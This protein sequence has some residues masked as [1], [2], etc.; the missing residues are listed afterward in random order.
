MNGTEKAGVVL[1]PQRQVFIDE[2]EEAATKPSNGSGLTATLIS[3][4]V[5]AVVIGWILCSWGVL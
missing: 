2:D 5:S 3:A 1:T 4:F